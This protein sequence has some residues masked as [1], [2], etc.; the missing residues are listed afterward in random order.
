MPDV[1]NPDGC[2]E[3]DEDELLVESTRY[4]LY[5]SA[6]RFD[7]A[8]YRGWERGFRFPTRVCNAALG[9]FTDDCPPVNQTKTGSTIKTTQD[10]HAAWTIYRVREDTLACVF[11]GGEDPATRLE[12]LALRELE[13]GREREIALEVLTGDR[14]LQTLDAPYL[15]MPGTPSLIDS[16]DPN[17]AVPPEIALALLEQAA[18]GYP[19]GAVIHAPIATFLDWAE[20]GLVDLSGPTPRTILGTSVV[21]DA[22]YAVGVGP[23]NQTP[24]CSEEWV[25]I[26]GKVGMFETPPFTN[27]STAAELVDRRINTIAVIVEQTVLV[28]WDQCL[29]AHVKVALNACKCDSIAQVA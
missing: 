12:R 25:Y 13:A 1:F 2:V 3:L 9:V 21:T 26:T 15:A 7:G 28:A 19:Y 20:D 17:E 16:V 24:S 5:K 14:C 22:G 11:P 27:G 29:H 10:C 6:P 4:S 23:D 8:R 18:A